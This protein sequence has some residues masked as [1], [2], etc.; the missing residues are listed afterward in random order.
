MSGDSWLIFEMRHQ[1]AC[2]KSSGHG[3]DLLTKGFCCDV[4]G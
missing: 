2:W 1:H 4:I 3:W